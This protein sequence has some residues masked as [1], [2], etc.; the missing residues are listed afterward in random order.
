MHTTLR[1]YRVTVVQRDGTAHVS[2]GDYS[3]GF[4]A[5]ISAMSRCPWARGISARRLA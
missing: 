4:A 3:D 2:V 1:A 5:V